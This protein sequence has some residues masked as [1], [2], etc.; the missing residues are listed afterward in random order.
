M[1]SEEYLKGFEDGR[2]EIL[3][4]CSRSFKEKEKELKKDE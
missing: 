1:K 4:Q 3:R 2:K